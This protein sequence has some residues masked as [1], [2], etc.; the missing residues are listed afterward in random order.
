MNAGQK[1]IELRSVD[2]EVEAREVP[3][4]L[5]QGLRSA[6]PMVMAT[7]PMEPS[8]FRERVLNKRVDLVERIMEGLPP[9]E[10][11]PESEGMLIA[12]K[13]HLIAAPR[14][15]GKSIGMLVH[16]SRM[17]LAD[18]RVIILDREN[19]AQTYAERLD[20]IITTWGLKPHDKTRIR[21][22]LH[23]YEFPRLRREDGQ[24]FSKM[25]EG[26][27][28]VVFD[29]QRMFLTDL[30]L[31]ESESDDYS[32]FMKY[33]V[34]PL[35]GAGVAT[36]ILDNTGHTE[37]TRS[38]G[39]SAKG[40]LNEVLFTLKTEVEFSRNRQGKLRLLLEPGNSR[41]GHEGEWEMHIGGGAFSPWQRVGQETPIDPTFQ[42]AAE[43]ALSD[44]GTEGLS[45]TKLLEA[46]RATEVTFSNT[47]GREWLYRLAANLDLAIY[48][49]PP[50]GPGLPT[51]FYGGAHAAE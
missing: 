22:N 29:S 42:R 13:R 27:A 38:R 34:E 18:T 17:A 3:R 35:F 1:I 19:G 47:V 49:F 8:D 7:A 26:A 50:D 41:F 23:Y 11:L 24:A 15:T 51:M 43:K 4:L 40:D 45:Q 21:R 14:K 10:Y 44:A 20:A 12:G 28:V 5:P 16:W 6:G 36:V 30:G 32:E 39:T 46:I 9:V 33:A 48:M 2:G 37:K 31:R 25:A